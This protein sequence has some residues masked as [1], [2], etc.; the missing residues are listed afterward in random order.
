MVVLLASMVACRPCI[1]Y[2][3]PKISPATA[4]CKWFKYW[5]KHRQKEASM[6]FVYHARTFEMPAGT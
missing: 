6:K 1:E 4:K 2:Y 3:S 5:N